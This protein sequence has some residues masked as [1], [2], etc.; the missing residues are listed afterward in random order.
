MTDAEHEELAAVLNRV[1]GKVAISNYQC[2]LMDK[3]YPASHWRKI[4]TGPRTNHATKGKRVEVLWTN[5]DP[6]E[7]KNDHHPRLF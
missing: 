1:R 6:S 4:V 2:A 3:L 5:Y 7:V